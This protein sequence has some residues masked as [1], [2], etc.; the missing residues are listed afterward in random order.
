MDKKH[1]IMGTA[2][3]V[4]HGK[5]ALI[6]TLTGFDC[7]T[8]K[9]EKQRGITMNLG[10]TH[11]D[12]PDDNSV[13]IIDVPGHADFIKTMV[14]GA[15]GI[16]FVLF[17]VAA[18]EGIMPQTREH[19]EIMNILGIKHGIIVLT[20]IDLVDTELIEL[21]EDELREFVKDSFLENASIVKVSSV[22]E[23]GMDKLL[24]AITEIVE[25]IPQR[26]SEGA[27]RLYIDRIFSQEGFGTITNGSVLSGSISKDD[28]VYLLP[29]NKEL[30]IRRLEHHGEE[31]NTVS[32]GDRASFNLVGLKQ[33]D[34]TRGMVLSDRK[35]KETRLI[36]AK[37]TI[38]QP[39]VSLQLWTQVIFLLGTGRLMARMHLLDKNSISSG[40]TCLVQIYLPKPIIAVFGDKFI[41][42]NSSGDLTLGGG[43]IIDPYPLHHRRRR[44]EQ[45]DIVKKLSSGDL[46][47][48]VLAEIRKAPL[49]LLHTD[50]A[51]KLN[52]QSDDL[53]DIIF[54]QLPGDIVFHQGENNILLMQKKFETTTRNKILTGLQEFHKKNPLKKTGKTFNELMGIFGAEQNETTKMTLKLLLDDMQEN[55]KLKHTNKSWA[56]ASHDVNLDNITQNLVEKVE[57]YLQ[58][59]GSN[60]A[61]ISEILTAINV[62]EKKLQQ[63]LSYLVDN[64]KVHFLQKKY[65]HH[66]FLEEAKQ[67]LIEYLQQNPDGISVAQ[68][69]D[70]MECNRTNSLIILEYFDSSSITIRRGNYRVLT[71]KFV[72]SREK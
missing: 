22:S 16:D 49:P 61:D 72:E 56:L 33:K 35:I 40:E 52:I 41:I 26:S 24:Q 44:E 62:D 19:L 25:E 6:R 59:V 20:K 10:F 38:F 2:G 27:F 57:S 15:C 45:I 34:F 66:D 31:V 4:D 48:L 32:A 55:G 70:I 53:I 21:A 29:G 50:I 8:H 43:E 28:K 5:T 37:I 12:L 58:N 13:G 60:S 65:F 46:K 1:L 39:D 3:H 47:E 36:D 11:L 71:K 42:R 17:I 30:R 64:G 51:N 68:F 67:Q 63:V 14:A 18:D 23:S 9:Q 69:R 54:R 7:D